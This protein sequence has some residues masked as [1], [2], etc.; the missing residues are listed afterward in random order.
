MVDVPSLR[1]PALTRLAV[2]IGLAQR[3]WFSHL[4]VRPSHL[5]TCLASLHATGL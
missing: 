3:L 4:R 2:H 5:I 1:Q